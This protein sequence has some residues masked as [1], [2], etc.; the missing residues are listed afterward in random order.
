M[1]TSR[2][3][4]TSEHRVEV[5]GAHLPKTAEGGA[6][7]F[8]V[9]HT[10]REK[11]SKVAQPPRKSVSRMPGIITS[12]SP[13]SQ[14]QWCQPRLSP[15]YS[16]ERMTATDSD[17]AIIKPPTHDRITMP[18]AMLLLIVGFCVLGFGC[19]DV[20]TTWSTEVPSPNGDW[21]ATA[22]SQQWGGP[23]T[24]Y[25]ATTVF[26]KPSKGTQ[27]PTQVLVFSHQYA[28]MFLKMDWITPTHLNVTYAASTRPSDHVSLDFQAVK[29]DGVEITVREIPSGAS[30]AP[31]Q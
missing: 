23:G 7:D 25:D 14:K 9:A 3:Y 18:R 24:A 20:A 1:E 12:P 31:T 11:K 26:L 6:A 21:L 17:E 28:T 8:G 19:Q 16:Y 2:L 13:S 10:L 29:C 4:V 15:H 27:P 22:R 5:R 30:N